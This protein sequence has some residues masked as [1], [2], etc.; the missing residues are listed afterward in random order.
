MGVM[1]V[2]SELEKEVTIGVVQVEREVEESGITI[3]VVLVESLVTLLAVQVESE[4]EE[5]VT[6]DEAMLDD[7]EEESVGENDD[8]DSTFYSFTYIGFL[9]FFLRILNVNKIIDNYL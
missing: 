3:V 6:D 1:W 5:E 9:F 4:V 2:E 8:Q 7:A